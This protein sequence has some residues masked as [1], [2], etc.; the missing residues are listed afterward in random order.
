MCAV[1]HLGTFL[2]VILSFGTIIGATYLERPLWLADKGKPMTAPFAYGDLFARQG[3]LEQQQGFPELIIS[4]RPAVP[5]SDKD[6]HQQWSQHR[7]QEIPG[8]R[9]VLERSQSNKPSVEN[10]AEEYFGSSNLNVQARKPFVGQ[11]EM[12]GGQPSIPNP[13][14]QQ[15][16]YQKTYFLPTQP[17]L[18][19]FKSS[20]LKPEREQHPSDAQPW[21]QSGLS[22]EDSQGSTNQMQNHRQEGQDAYQPSLMR[23]D[24]YQPGQP[25]P[26]AERQLS[27]YGQQLSQPNWQGSQ[28]SE[29]KPELVKP[30][31]VDLQPAP[32]VGFETQY[33][34]HRT[35]DGQR[36]L[37]PNQ[38][39]PDAQQ[40][41]QSRPDFGPQMALFGQQPFQSGQPRPDGGYQMPNFGQWSGEGQQHF[42]SNQPNIE[43]LMPNVPKPFQPKPQEFQLV[44]QEPEKGYQMSYQLPRPQ[45]EQSPYKPKPVRPDAYQPS[46]PKPDAEPQLPFNGQWPHDGPQPFKPTQPK[47]VN[48]RP[49]QYW[50]QAPT[51]EQSTVQSQKP[52]EIAKPQLEN[53]PPAFQN[54]PNYPYQQ[55]FEGNQAPFPLEQGA[56]GSLFGSQS[57]V[58]PRYP[59]E[60]AIDTPWQASPPN[61]APQPQVNRQPQPQR[62]PERPIRPAEREQEQTQ[63]QPNRMPTNPWEMQNQQQQQQYQEQQYEPQLQNQ[64]KQQQNQ[65]Q[66]QQQQ[67]YQ[68]QQQQQQQLLQQQLQQQHQQLQQ[69]QK[70]QQQ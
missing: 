20:Q 18:N 68:L 61:R 23:P 50:G 19:D 69:Q 64:H 59:G 49:V 45:E 13:Q 10:V 17:E 48:E 5:V 28:P 27:Y 38:V 63:Y 67:Q 6:E 62:N 1:S 65:Q 33:Q 57:P 11:S 44:P 9:P 46:Q 14:E 34:Q 47:P 60:Q 24:A 36:P 54:S 55:P 25:K 15:T 29:P 3:Q 4:P 40:A 42:P 32:E 39:R 2:V 37:K 35:Q 12:G 56:P 43:K 70:L 31:P 30:K 66:Q 21:K 52:S 58:K 22:W 7:E 53:K 41:S 51:N 26:D 8:Q 16:E